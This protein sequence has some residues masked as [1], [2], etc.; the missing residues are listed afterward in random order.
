M[1]SWPARLLSSSHSGNHPQSSSSADRPVRPRGETDKLYTCPE[2]LT[3]VPTLHPSPRAAASSGANSSRPSLGHSRS[4]SHPFPF[5]FGHGKKTERTEPGKDEALA[6]DLTDD[7]SVVDGDSTV[8]LSNWSR[9]KS[10]SGT[11][12]EVTTGRCIT[13][14]SLMRWPQHLKIFRCS[15]CGMVNDLKPTTPEGVEPTQGPLLAKPGNRAPVNIPRKPL[16]LSIEKTNSIIDHCVSTFLES[17]RLRKR[18]Q[19]LSPFPSPKMDSPVPNQEQNLDQ[20]SPDPVFAEYQSPPTSLNHPSSMAMSNNPYRSEMVSLDQRPVPGMGGLSQS[21]PGETSSAFTQMH[22]MASG[23]SMPPPPS[24]K[25]PQPPDQ[26]SPL[27]GPRKKIGERTDGSKDTTLSSQSDLLDQF[28]AG[29]QDAQGRRNRRNAIFGPLEEYIAN[30]FGSWQCVNA[31]FSTARPG[32]PIRA[33]SEGSR[34]WSEDQSSDTSARLESVAL[35]DLDAKTLLLGDFAEN[36]SW[37]SGNRDGAKHST[38]PGHGRNKSSGEVEAAQDLVSAKSPRL[39]W[40]QVNFWYSTVLHAGR[41]WRIKWRAL[42]EERGQGADGSIDD[43]AEG[44]ELRDIEESLDEARSLLQRTLLKATENLLKRPGRPLRKPEEIRFLLIILANPLLYAKSAPSDNRNSSHPGKRKSSPSRAEIHRQP[45][46]ERSPKPR[47]GPGQHSSLVKRILGL[48]SNLSSEC[49]A[50]LV[51]WFSRFSE[52]HFRRTVDLIGGFVTYRLGRQRRSKASNRTDPTDGLIPHLAGPGAAT[53]AQLHAA[54]GVSGPSKSSS[55]K[56]KTMDYDDDWQI[57][58][59]AKVMAILFTANNSGLAKKA[60]AVFA[61]TSGAEPKS[62]GLAARQRAHRH[63]QLLPTSDFYNTLLDYCDLVADFETWESKRS[64]FS[65]CQYPFF[66]SIW[67]KIKVLEFDA[68]RQM[69]VKAREAFFDSIIGRRVVDQFLILKVRRDCLVEDSLKG[70]SEVV[71]TGLEEI[72]KGLRI[73]FLG[74][75][76]IDAGGLRKEWFLLLVRE[77]FDPNHGMFVY[78]EQSHFCYFNPHCFETS[79]QFF[80]VGVLLGLAIYNSTI[81][82]IPFPPFTFKKLLASGPNLHTPTPTNPARVT[83]GYTLEDLAEFRPALARGLRQLLEFDGDVEETFC[84]DFVAE[85]ERYGQVMLVPLCPNG[86]TRPVTNANR[87]EFVDLYVRYLLDTAVARQFEPFKRGFYTVCGGNALSLFRPE[88]IELL[89]RGSDEP[90]DI[91]SLRAVAQYDNWDGP[92]PGKTEPVIQWFWEFFA[93]ANPKDQRTILGFIT[94]SDRIPAM[95][96]TNLIIKISCLGPHE[97]DSERF[98]I[99]RTCFNM[100]GLWKYASKTKLERK[101]WEGVTE[102]EGFGLK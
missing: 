57:K 69:E 2:N 102:S 74:E 43:T 23:Q 22:E 25:A 100:L 16:P 65:F 20:P 75:E 54:L 11:D 45:T 9:G 38:T 79:D 46:L 85:V 18:Q 30:C 13:C 55:D 92:D 29:N 12:M 58:A 26:A 48:L 64:K 14:D 1:P 33:A 87:R 27:P 72:K 88:E 10:K 81:L 60:E 59:A 41:N 17:R 66:L 97:E 95:G 78:D 77:I 73:V 8:N 67:A 63:G 99:A 82:D 90:L 76:G 44:E 62:A 28:R 3:A 32:P 80:L 51:A 50:H 4:L 37:W 47:G 83:Q 34:K 86:E 7:D 84:R 19:P 39:D 101:L 24:R 52:S 96:A 42:N 49:Q 31:S 94:G 98:P 35:S 5:I 93:G 89:V 36:G 70:V 56:S 40:G 68:R 6:L 21:L 61:T 71:G 15:I 91:S 53:S